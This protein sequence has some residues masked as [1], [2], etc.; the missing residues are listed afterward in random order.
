M[1]VLAALKQKEVLPEEEYTAWNPELLR[2]TTQ[3]KQGVSTAMKG[4]T[5]VDLDLEACAALE[6]GA[7][8]P[9]GGSLPFKPLSMTFSDL[10]Y[11]VAIPKV[12]PAVPPTAFG[13]LLTRAQVQP[14]SHADT[15]MA[16]P[17][18]CV[19]AA[20]ASSTAGS[21]DPEHSRQLLLLK[22]ITGSF[23]PGVLTALMGASGAGAALFEVRSVTTC[24]LAQPALLAALLPLL[25]CPESHARHARRQDHIDGLPGWTQDRCVVSL[26]WPGSAPGNSLSAAPA[27]DASQCLDCRA[28]QLPV[29]EAAEGRITGD[30]RLGGFPLNGKTFARVMGYV[31]QT[32]GEALSDRA[33]AFVLLKVTSSP[34]YAKCHSLSIPRS[35]TVHMPEATV[36][37]ALQFSAALRLQADVSSEQRACFVNEVWKSRLPVLP[38]LHGSC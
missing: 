29:L 33:A 12:C 4:S 16:T 15:A 26:T 31:E 25:H 34:A 30:M 14:G 36:L 18:R 2:G 6:N 35:C 10:K 11:S 37:E 23:R 8:K 5:A 20:Q 38:L 1:P 24:T 13:V 28:N 7:A 19:H 27:S 32:D 21:D 9:K 22:G 17:W 3:K